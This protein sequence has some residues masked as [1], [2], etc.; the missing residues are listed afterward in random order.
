MPSHHGSPALSVVIPAYNEAARILPY[1]TSMTCY[2]A[3]RGRSYEILVVDDGSR[4]ET[5][6]RVE[7]F[8]TD[9]PAVRLLQLARN[10]GKGGAVR[11]GMMEARG[12]LRLVADADGAT[13]IQELARLEAV[14]KQGADIAIGSRFLASQDSRYRVRARW[15]RTLLGNVFNWMVQRLGIA[16]IA[17][18]QCGFKLFRNAAAQDLFSVARV[19]G[20]GFDLELLYIAQRRGYGIVEVPVNWT[21]HPG[22]KVHVMRDGLQMFRDLL[23]V[24]DRYRLGGYARS[25][26]TE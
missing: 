25:D 19:N 1:L 11:S 2:L 7:K 18:T 13:P 24:R 21:D 3:R 16:G 10:T 8:R 22:S 9:E 14:I 26:R 12:D 15:H 20:Y 6:V 17:D 23:A 4:D 5:A